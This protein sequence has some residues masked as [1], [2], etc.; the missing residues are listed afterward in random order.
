MS[1]TEVMGRWT[2]HP[3]TSYEKRGWT[4][5]HRVVVEH[6]DGGMTDVRHEI[7]SGDDPSKPDGWTETK[8]AEIRDHGMRVHA[9]DRSWAGT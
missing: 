8:S 5:E 2:E 1:D 9:R 6:Y 7:R 3:Y 4:V